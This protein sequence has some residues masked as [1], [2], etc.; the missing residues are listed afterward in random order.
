[1]GRRDEALWSVLFGELRLVPLTQAKLYDIYKW[2]LSFLINAPM[3]NLE[4]LTNYIKAE[5]L[6]QI[7]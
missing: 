1:M 6:Q 3:R 2:S 4:L 7:A 5:H